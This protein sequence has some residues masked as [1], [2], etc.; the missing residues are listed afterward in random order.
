MSVQAVVPVENLMHIHL[1]MSFKIFHKTFVSSTDL[2]YVYPSL[3]GPSMEGY[4]FS[5]EYLGG[6]LQLR[7]M[8]YRQGPLLI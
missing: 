8:F 3:G 6:L 7:D 4:P 1:K 2:F 5:S